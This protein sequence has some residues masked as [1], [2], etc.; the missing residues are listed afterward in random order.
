MACCYAP[1][2]AYWSD[3][4]DPA[5]AVSA[6]ILC[7]VAGASLFMY[8][9]PSWLV[10]MIGVRGLLGFLMVT[11]LLSLLL[12]PL[13]PTTGVQTISRGETEVCAFRGALLPIAGLCIMGIYFIGFIG[14]WA[15]LGQ[16]GTAHGLSAQAASSALSIS[17]LVGAGAAMVTW[18]VG[19]RCGYV[20]PL[21]TSIGVYGLFLLLTSLA[22]SSFWFT[23]ALILFNIA[24]NVALPYQLEIIAKSDRGGRYFVLLPAFQSAGAAAGPYLAG[25]MSNRGNYGGVYLMLVLAVAVSF[26]GYVAI[27]VRLGLAGAQRSNPAT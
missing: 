2:L 3:V 26:V 13:V 22:K 16:I 8:A 9:V 11:L 1:V 23:T 17:L 18:I 5:R 15:F 7:Q 24:A 4:T 14:I 21:I 19:N 10:P 20:M 27:A 6:G 25:I 12:A